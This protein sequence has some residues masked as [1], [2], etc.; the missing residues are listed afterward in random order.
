MPEPTTN[1]FRS[2]LPPTSGFESADKVQSSTAS[3]DSHRYT[4]LRP[5]ARGG[6]GEVFRAA[7]AELGREVALKRIQEC[8]RGNPES[9]RRF[10]FEAAITARLEHPGIV[11]IHGLVRDVDG[12]PSYAMRFVEGESLDAAIKD[13]HRGDG[14]A[15]ERNVRFR[16]LLARFVTVCQTVGYAHSRGVIHRD[17][18]PANIM[19]GP[20]G[21]TLVVDWGLAKEIAAGETRSA[22]AATQVDGETSPPRTEEPANDGTQLGRALG[23]PQY[24]APEQAAGRWDV[25]GPASDIY[26]LG[27]VLYMLLTGRPPFEGRTVRE[28]LEQVQAGPFLPPH[29]RQAGVA[30]PLEAICLK[31]MAREPGARYAAAKG[32]ADD[33]EHWLADEP[34][35]CYREPWP[36]RASRFARKHRTLLTAAA[37]L[38][39]TATVGLSVGLVAVE[40]QRRQTASERDQKDQALRAE[41]QAR[42]AETRARKLTMSA[43]RKLTD[44]VVAQQLAGHIRL[45]DDDRQFLRDI[46]H[47]YEEF[48]ALPGEDAEQRAIRAEG[49]LRVGEVRYRLGEQ[50]QAE[51]AF[52]EG[53]GLYASLAAD[54]PDR[55]EYRQGLAAGQSHLGTLLFATGRHEDAQAAY[56]RALELYQQLAVEEP[57]DVQIRRGLASTHNQLAGLLQATGHLKE[58]EK[59]YAAGLGEQRR[60]AAD[61]PLRPE[62]RHELGR[63]HDNLGALLHNTGRLKEA[64]EA[65]REAIALGQQLVADFPG[66]PEYR[67]ELAR[68]QS[69]LAVLL[70]FTRRLPAA[71]K[72]YREAIASRKQLAADFPAQPSFRDD[73]AKSQR[74][75]GHLLNATGRPADA[76]AAYAEALVLHKQ[77]VA[78]F[79]TRVEFRRELGA[80]YLHRG[81]FFW[82]T[83][84]LKE[85]ETAYRDS[86]AL[87]QQLATEFPTRP[88]FRNELAMA[89]GNLALLFRSMSRLKDAEEAYTNALRV[90]RQLVT[91]LPARPEFR[92][93]LA[94]THSDL[95]IVLAT[96]GRPNEAEAAYGEA[97]AL[98][99]QLTVDFPTRSDFQQE[100]AVSQNDLGV[101]LVERGR[102]EDAQARYGDALV[103]RRQL[104]ADFP[105]V[106]DHRNNLAGTLVNMA[107]LCNRRSDY[108][109]ARRLLTKALPH[110]QAALQANPRNGRYQQFY[111]TNILTLVESCARDGD[112]AAA[113]E[114][115]NK[116]RD[117]GR[118]AAVD[119]F[120][121]ACALARCIPL[122]TKE[123]REQQVQ[124]YGNGAMVLLRDAVAKGFK[125]VAHMKKD[126]DLDGLRKRTDFQE[127]TRQ[128]EK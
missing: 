95:A 67:L 6:L 51:A 21:E 8:H 66:R 120:D 114:A 76:E 83:S 5:H 113:L 30:R 93:G 36:A 1:D 44:E 77:L 24:M 128:L 79:P 65:Y 37:V 103:L 73:L 125:D 52:R 54:F 29:K 118:D 99:K 47:Q 91:D 102:L 33:V 105:N 3:A 100:L 111:R 70:Q 46:Q 63:S 75:L 4:N 2:E 35:S 7:D 39:V 123:Q 40:Y 60:L 116:M 104:A 49:H 15:G 87:C 12:Q 13:Y 97:I 43:L 41:T 101:L 74:N 127:L 96:T 71:E 85:A 10:L 64:E 107:Q 98:Q 109:T 81:N 27:A 31:A 126:P 78:D 26:S 9:L 69:N 55:T 19:L 42:A 82:G 32:L 28:V 56:T 11:P 72:A 86:L 23:T 110:H 115:A 53:L 108:S 121:A 38:L 119:E 84:R 90:Y 62:V 124:V 80:D 58:A 16:Q 88:E 57:T 48:A 61:F 92:Q 14:P 68:S 94:R 25:V 34:V 89:Q 22:G 45:T 50:E 117:L 18:K 20:F 106:P 17:L 112:P 59:A 122:A